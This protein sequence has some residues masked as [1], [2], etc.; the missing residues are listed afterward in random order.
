MHA[1]I[2]SQ[3]ILLAE[4]DRTL[5]IA[6]S[7]PAYVRVREYLLAARGQVFDEAC[8]LVEGA[9]PSA[10]VAVALVPSA[11]D[12]ELG[13]AATSV[14][15]A[16]DEEPQSEPA[17]RVVHGDPVEEVVLATALR[18]ASENVDP[19]PISAFLARLERN[20][21]EAS[22]SQ[23]FGWLK[24]GGFTITTDGLI[25]GYK[26]VRDD[27]LSVH[28][29]AEPVTVVHQDGT[30]ETVTGHVPHPVGATVW[31]SRELVDADRH[32]ACSIGLH[33]GTYNYAKGF[34]TTM[35]VVL[36]DPAD[37][38]SVPACSGDQK[39]RVCRLVV[40]AKHDGEQIAEAV[41]NRIRTIPDFA[42]T[43]AYVSRPENHLRASQGYAP[44]CDGADEEW[45]E[46]DSTCD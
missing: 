42:A 13:S 29:G 5:L 9:R 3:S 41:I 37:V 23:L 15:A 7:D 19:A 26:S 33:V 32:P 25:V 44:F 6:R 24:A 43:E 31:M 22:R 16:V 36:V 40:A 8:N 1:L 12:G 38:V 27:G 4:G 28:R 20:P 14:N 39:V 11:A 21:S 17:C 10:K 18:L 30:T 46:R 2:D 34:S 45:D 35:L